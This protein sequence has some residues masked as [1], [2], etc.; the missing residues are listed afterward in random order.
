MRRT[1]PQAGIT[2]RS[3]LV[4]PA[5]AP[6]VRHF[7]IIPDPDTSVGV[8]GDV[9][10][11]GPT[12]DPAGTEAAQVQNA[13]QRAWE[14]LLGATMSDVGVMAV[15]VRR[16]INT[17]GAFA[18]F[19]VAVDSGG[20]RIVTA[21]LGDDPSC[22]PPGTKILVGTE[23]ND[24]LLGTSGRDCILGRGGNDI[25]IGFHG[26]DFLSGGGGRDIVK[27]GS[28]DDLLVGGEGDDL[29]DGHAGRD[30]ADGGRGKDLCL[31]AETRTSWE[32]P[33]FFVHGH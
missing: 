13:C 20:R 2:L 6:G 31:W 3:G 21:T 11:P 14:G 28:G 16:L 1:S 10:L 27:G 8:Y 24:L 5:R 9:V 22:C 30:V 33:P 32:A 12:G 26:D 4:E 18:A 25:I 15:N 7:P 17:E 19:G 23:K 29:L